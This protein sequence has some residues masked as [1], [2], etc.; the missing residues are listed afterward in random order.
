MKE[1]GKIGMMSALPRGKILGRAVFFSIILIAL[2]VGAICTFYTIRWSQKPFAGFLV[3]QRMVYGVVGQYHWTG[4]QAG[5][6]YPDKILKANGIDVH[7]PKD[8]EKVLSQTSIGT[9]V[10]YT[11]DRNGEIY[12]VTIETMQFS[13]ADLFIIFGSYLI[14][15]IIYL[16]IG[17]IVFILKP[18]KNVSWTF[19]LGCFLMSLSYSTAFDMVSTHLGFLRLSLFADALIPAVAIHFSLFFPEEKKIAS[20]HKILQFIPYIIATLL[21]TP[22]V[23]LYPEPLAINIY[24]IFVPNFNIIA[25]GV[26]LASVLHS[27]FKKSSIIARQ[28]AKVIFWGAAIAFPIPIIAEILFLSW[29]YYTRCSTT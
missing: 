19:L 5:L 1:A 15:S 20:R 18:D 2:I 13:F 9:P 4:T 7:S 25:I 11:V 10:T 8:M 6:K 26:L 17:V 3:N 23:A 27:F 14:A 28:R 29:I 22:V 21:I 12:E 16:S 24:S